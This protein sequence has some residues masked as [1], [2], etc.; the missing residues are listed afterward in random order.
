MNFAPAYHLRTNK[1]VERLLFLELLHRLD[2][3]F[4]ELHATSISDYTYVGLGGPYL[5]DFNLIHST[6]GN[7]K[8]ISL[9]IERD[10]LTRQAIN[11]PC[12]QVSLTNLSTRD[13]IDDLRIGRTPSI[14]WLD[15]SSQKWIDQLAECFDSIPKL[16]PMSI[17]KVTLTGKTRQ[18][19]ANNTARAEKLSEMF[20]DYGPFQSGDVKPERICRTLF[21]IFRRALADAAPDTHSRAVR[22]LAAYE[23]NDGTP[24]L[25]MTMIVG[26]IAGVEV[27][28]DEI[29]QWRFSAVNWK[30]PRL[31]D[32]PPLSLREKLAVDRLLPD[33]HPRTVINK[34]N[35]R[36]A[37]KYEDSI[38]VM[39]NYVELYR[40]VPQFVRM[41]L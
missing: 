25:T 38:A 5:E 27:V 24:V 35:L 39:S 19:G 1:A 26:P 23:Y 18:L 34:L 36:F 33:A 20:G 32:V 15:Y 16:A 14:V 30:E 41:G 17:L 22:S 40:F 7:R 28:T 2:H 8:M 31:I 4:G 11:R 37:D 9:E 21:G 13:Y 29:S 12:S 10:V 3:V 6:F